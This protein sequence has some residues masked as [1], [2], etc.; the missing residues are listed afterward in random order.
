MR[1]GGRR[2]RRD[3]HVQVVV[4]VRVLRLGRVAQVLLLKEEKNEIRL[5]PQLLSFLRHS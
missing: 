1:L 5:P 3:L 4:Q 2:E